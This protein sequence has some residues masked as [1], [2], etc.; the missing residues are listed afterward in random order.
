M[1]ALASIFGNDT[2]PLVSNVKSA[3][4][5]TLGAASVFSTLFAVHALEAQSVAPV[6]DLAPGVLDTRVV[7]GGVQQAALEV[8]L[9]NGIELGGTITSLVLRK[10]AVGGLV[11]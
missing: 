6:W 7:A 10:C 3:I 8:A 1:D 2:K 4:G 5:E 11:H 9:V